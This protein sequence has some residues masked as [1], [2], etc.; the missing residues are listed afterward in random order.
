M[1]IF[2][3]T[4]DKQS[5]LTGIRFSIVGYFITLYLVY[6]Y[7][8]NFVLI[9][10]FRELLTIPMFLAQPLFLTI[11]VKLLLDKNQNSLLFKCSVVVLAVCLILTVSSFF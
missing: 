9:G 5:A 10:V 8:M 6:V 1:E 11:G 3:K 4:V 2:G 7:K